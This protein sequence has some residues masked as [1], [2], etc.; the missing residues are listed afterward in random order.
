MVT[1]SDHEFRQ[2]AEYIKANYGIHL[3]DEKKVLVMG[4]LQK[5]LQDTGCKSFSEYYEYLT[6]D[7]SG[8]A[9]ITMVNKITTNHT[10]FMREAEHFTYFKNHVLPYLKESVNSKDLRIWCA[11]SSTG[12][13]P[14]TLA[15]I[16]D[17]FLGRDKIYW[18]S[19]ILATDISEQALMQAIEGIYSS[20]R[21]ETIPKYW[22]LHY[23][24]QIDR[25]NWKITDKLKQEVIFRKFNLMEPNF[26]FRKKFHVIFCRNVMIYFDQDTKNRLVNKFYDSLEDGGYLFIGHSETVSKSET[27]LHYVI[28]SVYRKIGKEP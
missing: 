23:F 2:L 5:V 20:E 12:E 13:E 8:Q 27:K 11:A 25:D 15:M 14:Y 24:E 18:D 22:K 28:P 19:R 4:R 16:V 6:S 9:V 3:K 7:G 10:F 1:I 17:E 26:P 21:L